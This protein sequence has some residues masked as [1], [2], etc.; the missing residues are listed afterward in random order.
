MQ[1]VAYRISEM[2]IKGK[3]L[4]VSTQQRVST[5][6]ENNCYDPIKRRPLWH[7]D[8]VVLPVQKIQINAIANPCP[9][10]GCAWIGLQSIRLTRNDVL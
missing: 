7:N 9:S 3:G 1:Q 2:S 6:L 10:R 5:S 8:E 4:F